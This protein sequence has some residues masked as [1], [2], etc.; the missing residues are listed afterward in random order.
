[1]VISCK[2]CGG[3]LVFNPGDTYGNCLHCGRT[4]TLP[5]IADND[6][7]RLNLY[8]LANAFLISG[9]YEKAESAY[10]D[11]LKMDPD[12][13]EAHWGRLLCKFGVEYVE[14]PS[15]RRRIPTLN[16][17]SKISVLADIDFEIAKKNARDSISRSIYQQDAEEIASIQRQILKL[18]TDGKPFDVFICYKDKDGSERR[19][20]DS[21][22]AEEIYKVLTNRGLHVFF[23]RETL[24]NAAG[25]QFEPIIYAAISTARIMIVVT[26]NKDYVSKE[27]AWVYNEWNRYLKRMNVG[28]Q[29]LIPCYKGIPIEE[30][31]EELKAF[32]SYDIG[33]VTFL[34][35]LLEQ[36]NNFL[37][38]KNKDTQTDNKQVNPSSMNMANRAMLA[39]EESDFKTAAQFAE[40]ALNLD[41]FN[42][43]AY[44]CKLLIE[45]QLQKPEQLANLKTPLDKS[46]N[47]QRA[48]RYSD[49]SVR[50]P[51]IEM[52]ERIILRNKQI[53]EERNRRKKILNDAETKLLSAETLSE[54]N[55]IM[56]QLK[57]ISD[58]E[59]VNDVLS[60]CENKKARYYEKQYSLATSLQQ[61]KDYSAALKTYSTI[62]GY[63]DTTQR[64]EFCKKEIQRISEAEKI[65]N[66]R[67]RVT[68]DLIT[69]GNEALKK[70]DFETSRLFFEQVLTSQPKHNDGSLGLLFSLLRVRNFD[71]LAG[72]DA[73]FDN[74]KEYN[75]LINN[76]NDIQQ[77]AIDQCLKKIKQRNE[78]EKKR[79]VVNN[80]KKALESATT[81][82]ECREIQEQIE[83]LAD[84]EG[85]RSVI[86]DCDIKIN[87]IKSEEY[88]SAYRL[89]VQEEWD[90]AIEIYKRLEGYND[91]AERIVFC[92][93]QKEKKKE[94]L[95]RE[96]E[97]QEEKARQRVLELKKKQKKHRLFIIFTAIVI[98]LVIIYVVYVVPMMYYSKG[99]EYAKKKEWDT[100]IAEFKLAG[101]YKDSE[102]QIKEM[103][104]CKAKELQDV[105]DHSTAIE[106][107]KSLRG[108]KLSEQYIKLSQ[109]Q[110]VGNT[111]K[112]GRYE[113]DND[114]TNGKEDIEWIVLNVQEDGLCVL[115]TR[116]AL[117]AKPFSSKKEKNT[118]WNNSTVR[119]WLN[120]EFYKDAFSEETDILLASTGKD[121]DPGNEGLEINDAIEDDKVFLLG[122][123]EINHFFKTKDERICSA[124]PYLANMD[125][126]S[127]LFV[128]TDKNVVWLLRSIKQEDGTVLG[129]FCDG[130]LC[131][132]AVDAIAAIRPAICISTSNAR[133]LLHVKDMLEE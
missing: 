106:L 49:D 58:F 88:L 19:T 61:R 54:I 45:Y 91:S 17:M 113:Q 67:K 2:M 96:K 47:Y 131:N 124:T 95:D 46:I 41:A 81:I 11:I 90:K 31:P 128:D 68:K 118:T 101:N 66:E 25:V 13:A 14:D 63:K 133:L 115:T 10:E 111:I 24:K 8:R 56:R 97:V 98:I 80:A 123:Q 7:S 43:Y 28:T 89:E 1:M 53:I 125:K 51:L 22:I 50:K 93:M 29:L 4:S 44:L 102:V 83:P 62:L 12:E 30:L 99:M 23:S 20:E 32:Q 82:E 72:L 70:K 130:S 73:P 59:G 79:I 127:Q 15:T 55:D 34:E 75:Q 110:I 86:T 87:R 9:E 5:K 117:D 132:G 48:I 74:V 27:S 39:L 104:Y 57:S 92:K 42:G 21:E 77:M 3:D 103:N 6:T 121:N 60:Q 18:K 76:C 112:Y 108:Y 16:R 26:T 84:F 100:A 64:I 129:V 36:V 94:E 126:E 38:I 33:S 35:Q 52:N 105:G 119:E 122:S 40:Q 116:Y 85:V 65:L 107:Y 114:L 69:R 120:N 78:N 109:M 37:N 71:E